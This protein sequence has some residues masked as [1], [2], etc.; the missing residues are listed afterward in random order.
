MAINLRLLA[1]GNVARLRIASDEPAA[2]PP[3]LVEDTGLKAADEPVSDAEA[4]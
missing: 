2:E 3:A 1:S 4:A